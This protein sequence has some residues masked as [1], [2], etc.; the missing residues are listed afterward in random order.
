MLFKIR[1][2]PPLGNGL[3]SEPGDDLVAPGEGTVLDLP[4]ER[5][6]L[7]LAHLHWATP[8]GRS[9]DLAVPAGGEDQAGGRSWEPPALVDVLVGAGFEVGAVEAHGDVVRAAV[10]RARSLPDTVG[11]GMGLLVCGLN[12]SKYAADRGVG[13]ARPGNRFWPAAVEAGIVSRQ[14]DPVH[15]L[16]VHGVGMT[17]L[18]KRATARASALS[19][20]EY[21]AGAA[22]V[23]RLVRWLRPGVVC[24]VGLAS[25]RAAVDPRAAPG[26]QPRPWAG[27]PAYVMP[28]TSGAN[29][30]ASAATLVAH[31][32]A[33]AA[34]AEGDAAR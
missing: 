26:P 11:P 1:L 27:R 30:H 7:A 13:Y 16:V 25:W 21:R 3:V 4:R 19:A 31:L 10:T 2:L 15:A 5:L 18:V 24:V 14:H 20:E 32:R 33:A 28:S 12:P 8:V 9:L 34:L 23:E 17:D 6:P 22:R 29:A